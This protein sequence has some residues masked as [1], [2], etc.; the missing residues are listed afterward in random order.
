M[1]NFNSS[2]QQLQLK[3]LYRQTCSTLDSPRI[4]TV[5]PDSDWRIPAPA[6]AGTSNGDL[7]VARCVHPSGQGQE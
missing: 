6:S 7:L 1:S 4:A 2:V 3:T 5:H